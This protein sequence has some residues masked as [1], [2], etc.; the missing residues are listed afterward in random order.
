MT[1][2]L[3]PRNPGRVLPR[4]RTGFGAASGLGRLRAEWF[5]AQAG[6]VLE[7]ARKLELWA[8]LELDRFLSKL[9]VGEEAMDVSSLPF[10]H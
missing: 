8:Q 5:R 4:P 2:R 9:G 3:G 7:Q 1:P 6:Q 10:R